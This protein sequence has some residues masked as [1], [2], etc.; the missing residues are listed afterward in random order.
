MT[1]WF[2]YI[3][4]C[5]DESLY[6]GVTTDLERRLLEHN[7]GKAAARY[8][9]VRRPLQLVY[10]EQLRDRSSACKREHQIKRLPRL[11]KQQLVAEYQSG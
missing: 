2:V 6:T 7:T 10:A 5:A 1:E 11:K 8:T 4:E 3:L 9:R